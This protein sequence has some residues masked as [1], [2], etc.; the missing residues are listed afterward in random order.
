MSYFGDLT[1]LG[2]AHDARHTQWIDLCLNHYAINFASQ[3]HLYFLDANGRPVYTESPVFYW[4]Y[5]NIR[6]QY[7]CRDGSPWDHQWIAF[8]G[9]RVKSFIR[10][11]LL[12]SDTKKFWRP[13]RD[14]GRMKRDFHALLQYLNERPYGLDRAVHMFEGLLLQIMEQESIPQA[15]APLFNEFQNLKR[16]I[17]L[18]PGKNWDFF[19]VAREFC[20]SYSAF[21]RLFRQHLRVPPQEYVIAAR[22]D[23][24]ATFLR[25]KAGPIH[26]AAV[27]AGIDDVYYFSKL[28]K[29]KIGITPSQY[30]RMYLAPK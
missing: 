23:R 20:M 26:E 13:L 24:A 16:S 27:Q 4:T 1:F 12:P 15:H 6:F 14:L 19:S 2:W 5:P 18:S 25:A 8:K 28:F 3:G 21:R 22:L 10:S 9:P 7:G 30:K 29:K 11:G 17:D